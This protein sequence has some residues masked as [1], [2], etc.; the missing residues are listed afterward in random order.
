MSEATYFLSVKC[1]LKKL[2][3]DCDK[4]IIPIWRAGLSLN[5]YIT[6]YLQTI[7]KL[8]IKTQIVYTSGLIKI[9][10][11]DESW[12]LTEYGG[13]DGIELHINCIWK[14]DVFKMN[15]INKKDAIL[16]P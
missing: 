15:A 9:S 5:I 16:G 10:W 11:T 13:V 3:E 1:Y 8:D 7:K 14:P 12:N 2:T 6:F 4:R